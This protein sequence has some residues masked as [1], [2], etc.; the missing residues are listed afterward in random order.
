MK[1]RTSYNTSYFLDLPEVL[2]ALS[3]CSVTNPIIERAISEL[4]KL[5]NCEAHV[6]YMIDKGEL[7]ALKNLGINVTCEPKM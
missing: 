6:T 4:E 7:N 5:R 3:I 1:Q 2:I